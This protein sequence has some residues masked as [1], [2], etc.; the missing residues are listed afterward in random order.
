MLLSSQGRDPSVA[1]LV[2]NRDVG[3]L[4][5]FV[6]HTI[7]EVATCQDRFDQHEDLVD[8]FAGDTSANGFVATQARA[9]RL[10]A[11]LV[12]AKVRQE[13][14]YYMYAATIESTNK[15]VLIFAK[16]ASKGFDESTK[17]M[18]NNFLKRKLK[19]S[20]EWKYSSGKTHKKTKLLSLRENR[21]L[22]CCESCSTT[23]ET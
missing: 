22:L 18:D 2:E 12:T 16:S 4:R 11:C 8:A 15:T 5:A 14:A 20:D 17:W 21:R 13:A 6:D 23:I 7:V 3:E 10:E 1:N 19:E 9:N